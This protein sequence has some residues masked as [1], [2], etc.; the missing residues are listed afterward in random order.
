M[1]DVNDIGIL[2]HGKYKGKSCF[3][4]YFFLNFYRTRGSLNLKAGVDIGIC[5]ILQMTAK[6]FY[7]K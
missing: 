7:L 2:N 6:F 3:Y 1:R 4:F 5:Y